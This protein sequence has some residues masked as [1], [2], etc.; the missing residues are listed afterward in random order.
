MTTTLATKASPDNSVGALRLAMAEAAL[1]AGMGGADS[2]EQ[3]L[4]GRGNAVERLKHFL[5]ALMKHRLYG[6]ARTIADQFNVIV[7]EMPTE[8]VD[9]V[10]HPAAISDSSEECAESAYRLHRDKMSRRRFMADIEKE[11]SDKLRLYRALKA[12]DEAE[13]RLH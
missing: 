3:F 6:R 8:T 2:F 9:A 13:G 1:D 12:E 7:E 4:L 11:V 10:L 5:R